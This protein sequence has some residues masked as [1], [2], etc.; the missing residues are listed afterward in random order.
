[1]ACL[2]ASASGRVALNCSWAAMRLWNEKMG[3]VHSGVE[4]LIE[5]RYLSGCY[6]IRLKPIQTLNCDFGPE[7]ITDARSKPT[8]TSSVECTMNISCRSSM[9]P[10]IQLLN[11]A[12]LFANSKNSWSIVSSSFSVRWGHKRFHLLKVRISFVPCLLFVCIHARHTNPRQLWSVHIIGMASLTHI[13]C[14]AWPSPLLVGEAQ[15]RVNVPCPHHS[16]LILGTF[17]RYLNICRAA[18]S[19]LD[20][21]N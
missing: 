3:R 12:D 6:F 20:Q 4:C 15:K 19:S 2:S 10:S 14:F 17:P 16:G 5:A 21:R 8:W 1:M 18:M 13:F 9:A 7:A 11:G